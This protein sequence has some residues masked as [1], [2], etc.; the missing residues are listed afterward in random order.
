VEHFLKQSNESISTGAY[1]VS[2]LEAVLDYLIAQ[3]TG[4]AHDRGLQP[5]GKATSYW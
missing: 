4:I 3:C 2:K 1:D 5:V